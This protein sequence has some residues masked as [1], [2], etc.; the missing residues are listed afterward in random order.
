MT[1]LWHTK[2]GRLRIG[3]PIDDT[4]RWRIRAIEARN[5][6]AEMTDPEAKRALLF[7]AAA[8]ERLARGAQKRKD[9]SK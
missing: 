2:R 1:F 5:T 9:Q 8:Y 6:A 3:M 4:E 7:I